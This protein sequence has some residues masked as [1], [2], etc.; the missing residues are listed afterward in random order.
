M[1]HDV[2]SASELMTHSAKLF[3]RHMFDRWRAATANFRGH[4]PILVY[5]MGK[6]GSSAVYQSLLRANSERPVFQVHF[7]SDT[8][9]KHSAAYFTQSRQPR[10]PHWRLG[11]ALNKRLKR[12]GDIRPFTISLVRDPVARQV[13]DVFENVSA[14][15][16][17]RPGGAQPGSEEISEFL[18]DYFAGDIA[19]ADYPQKW[20]ATEIGEFFDLDVFEQPFDR[21]AGCQLIAGERTDLLLMTMESLADVFQPAMREY[22]DMDVPLVPANVGATK[23]YAELYQRVRDTFSLPKPVLEEIYSRKSTRH[24]YSAQQVDKFIA[25]WSE[26]GSGAPG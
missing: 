3:H 24:F 10:P 26:P 5:Q 17:G 21:S 4:P 8:G 2:A 16:P 19:V 18:Q 6:V 12:L 9:L 7:L 22:L 23:A 14:Y 15:F 20:F 13:S 1:H 25:R 11:A